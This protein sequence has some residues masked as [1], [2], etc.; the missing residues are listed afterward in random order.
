M[1]C[2]SHHKSEHAHEE[3]KVSSP[4]EK[5]LKDS[6]LDPHRPRS[7]GS[8]S[9][10]PSMRGSSQGSSEDE[11]DTPGH[12]ATGSYSSRKESQ[13]GRALLLPE[14]DSPTQLWPL[15]NAG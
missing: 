15:S 8:I 14:E 7:F 12:E 6:Q 10:C 11:A 2:G 5:D 3:P 13:I 1:G 4:G 9:S